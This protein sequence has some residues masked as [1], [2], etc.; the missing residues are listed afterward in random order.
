M[1]YFPG[2]VL[3]YS[4]TVN[5]PRT[6][7]LMD[8]IETYVI[9]EEIFYK[10]SLE[11]QAEKYYSNESD[12]FY[13][14]AYAG[15]SSILPKNSHLTLKFKNK[16]YQDIEHLLKTIIHQPRYRGRDPPLGQ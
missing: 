9:R 3:R 2:P 4:S 11:R 15:L 14:H 16:N 10:G 12:G 7:L 1:G 13:I 5:I 8:S 6:E